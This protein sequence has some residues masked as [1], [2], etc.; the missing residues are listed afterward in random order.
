MIRH[1]QQ[2][3]GHEPSMGVARIYMRD[4]PVSDLVYVVKE[5]NW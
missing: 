4:V 1:L 3:V 5:L 2:M